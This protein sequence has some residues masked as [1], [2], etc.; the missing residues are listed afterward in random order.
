MAE[1][2]H[3]SLRA[4]AWTCPLRGD[5]LEP[6]SGRRHTELSHK[7][8]QCRKAFRAC[9]I[10]RPAYR[11]GDRH[12]AKCRGL[13]LSVQGDRHAAPKRAPTGG[14]TAT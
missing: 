12:A 4:L 7:E 3:E 9:V 13:G 6:E 1:F 10:A 8:V 5:E 11:Q 14:T 2:R